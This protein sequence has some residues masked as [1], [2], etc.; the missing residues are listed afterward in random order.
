[1]PARRGQ[2]ESEVEAVGVIAEKGKAHDAS[3]SEARQYHMDTTET[4]P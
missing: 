4:P 1:M 3:F 2:G